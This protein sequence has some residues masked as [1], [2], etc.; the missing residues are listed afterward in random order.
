MGDV[1]ICVASTRGGLDVTGPT[2]SAVQFVTAAGTESRTYRRG[3]D[4]EVE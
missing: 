1:D 3:R 2:E 4:K